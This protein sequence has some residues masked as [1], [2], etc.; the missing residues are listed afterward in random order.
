MSNTI[1]RLGDMVSAYTGAVIDVTAAREH[2]R[3]L[4]KKHFRSSR[5]A[6]AAADLDPSTIAKIENLKYWPKYDPGI[7]VILKLLGAMDLTLTDFVTDLRE[8][9]H[10]LVERSQNEALQARPPAST[11]TTPSAE[12]EKADHAAASMAS[13]PS[14]NVRDLEVF[15][16]AFGRAIVEEFRR[17]PQRKT[18]SRPSEKPK[19]RARARSDARR[20][21]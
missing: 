19:R 13:S 1:N 9:D 10:A 6:A 11:T 14:V 5:K 2:L 7:G 12:S 21:G 4:R 8:I 16:R 18:K 3:Y 20:R 15:G 17:E